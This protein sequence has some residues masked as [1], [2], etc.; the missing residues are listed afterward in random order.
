[1]KA[2]GFEFNTIRHENRTF[3]MALIHQFFRMYLTLGF[4]RLRNL[5]MTITMEFAFELACY[6]NFAREKQRAFQAH[7][8]SDEREIRLWPAIDALVLHEFFS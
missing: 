6:E 1:M 8:R 5:K 2:P 4:T 3:G 7:I